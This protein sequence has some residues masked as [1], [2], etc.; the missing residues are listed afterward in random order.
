[1]QTKTIDTHERPVP[2]RKA[3]HAEQCDSTVHASRRAT[4]ST[5]LRSSRWLLVVML[6]F[7]VGGAVTSAGV[8]FVRVTSGSM[9]PTIEVGDWLLVTPAGR[10]DLERGDVIEFRY[11]SGSSGRAIKRIVAVGDD[12]V[13]VRARSIT[14]NDKTTQLEGEPVSYRHSTLVVPEGFVY[15]LGDNSAGS[16]DS[17][18]FGP[19]PT[20]ELVGQVRTVVP[21]PRVVVAATF[22]LLSS[23]VV[24]KTIR[25]R[26]PCSDVA[27]TCDGSPA[28]G[29]SGTTW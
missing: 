17:R 2:P 5:L 24:Y 20:S 3:S 13:T 28:T 8:T 18:G 21:S 15:L 6:G 7:G 27:T 26:S 10:H 1:M 29:S 14:V 4:R 23:I 9:S 25:H 12:V 19:V 22:F 11:P 16:V